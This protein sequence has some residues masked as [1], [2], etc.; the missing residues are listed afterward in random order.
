LFYSLRFVKLEVRIVVLRRLKSC[1]LLHRVKWWTF[2][3]VSK[4]YDYYKGR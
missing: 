1:G 3:D 4:A 2:T